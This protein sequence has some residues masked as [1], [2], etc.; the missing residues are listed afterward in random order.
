MIYKARDYA[1][2]F[3]DYGNV[4]YLISKH[5]HPRIFLLTLSL[6][7]FEQELAYLILILLLV[8]DTVLICLYFV[9]NG[10]EEAQVL[11]L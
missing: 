8:P 3:P 6:A 1:L 2:L 10:Q 7:D 4:R 11:Y 5:H 9:Q